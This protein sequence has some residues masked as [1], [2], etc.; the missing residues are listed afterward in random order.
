MENDVPRPICT[1][2]SS[3]PRAKHRATPT[4]LR[5]GDGGR[6]AAPV[7]LGGHN[8]VVEGAQSEA[9]AF[10]GVEVVGRVDR[11]GGALRLA[12]TPELSECRGALDRGRVGAGRLVDVVCCAIGINRPN[13][14]EA[15]GRVV[16]LEGLAGVGLGCRVG[17]LYVPCR[18]SRQCNTR[19]MGWWSTRKWRGSCSPMDCNS[20]RSLWCGPSR[21]SF[22]GLNVNTTASHLPLGRQVRVGRQS[23]YQPLPPTKLPQ[24][25]HW[26]A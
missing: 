17:E 4:S 3:S 23:T 10:P 2:N 20:L 7:A 12:D 18:S 19:S 25:V 24:F 13:L 11:A 1:M 26:T 22:Y 21:G 16:L 9:V 14:R 6:A 5:D 15:R 8:L